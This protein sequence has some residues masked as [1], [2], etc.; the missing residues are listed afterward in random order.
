MVEQQGAD[1][2]ES[3]LSIQEIEPEYLPSFRARLKVQPAGEISAAATGEIRNSDIQK[4]AG[5]LVPGAAGQ[6]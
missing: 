1:I 3:G 6:P 2:I 5:N 4:G